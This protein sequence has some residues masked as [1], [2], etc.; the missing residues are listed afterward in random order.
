MG[1]SNYIPKSDT[2]E[3]YF[4]EM[5]RIEEHRT[6]NAEKNIRY[7]YKNMMKEIQS[8]MSDAYDKF[9][10]DE[11]LNMGM[12]QQNMEYSRF[13]KEVEK[14]INDLAPKAY[15]EIRK[16]SEEMYKVAFDGVVKAV[17]KSK[18]AK[19][20]H[21]NLKGIKVKP[22]VLKRNVE[23][24][25]KGLTLS[26]VLESNR[27]QIIYDIRQE[28]NSGLIVGDRFETMAKR[29]ANKTNM[30]YRKAI[31]IVRT[32]A[33]RAT[34]SGS[35]DASNEIYD[36]MKNS[37]HDIVMVK[38]WH[39]KK[40]SHVRHT[41]KAS[42]QEMD[43]QIVLQD[44]EF[45]LYSG[46][47]KN[48]KTTPSPCQSGIACQD[49]N[50][51]CRA[52]RDIMTI[53]EFEKLTGRKYEKP[54]HESKFDKEINNAQMNIDS[55]EEQMK[56]LDE[57]EY[58]NIWK[59]PVTAKDYI[60]KKSKIKAK[61]DYFN[62]KYAETYDDKY[63]DL[64]D[65]V[66][67]FEKAGKQYEKLQKQLQEAKEKYIDILKNQEK[68]LKAELDKLKK[69]ADY[70]SLYDMD[71][72]DF[73]KAKDYFDDINVKE[74]YD[75]KWKYLNDK[76]AN[77]ETLNDKAQKQYD[78]LKKFFDALDDINSVDQKSLNK[79][80]AALDDF[81]KKYSLL[82]DDKWSAER[83]AAA[84]IF[85]DRNNADKY[86]RKILDEQWKDFDEWQQ[87]SVWE[88]TQNSNPM[89]KSLS[90]YVDSWSRSSF[91]G[92][93]KA[94]WN[95]ENNWRT[96]STKTFEKKFATNGHKTYE[97]V[98]SKLTQTI[99]KCDFKDDVWLVRGSDSSGLA[100]LLEGELFSFDEAKKLID[101]N[102]DDFK[103]AVEG[104][105][106]TNH[107]FTST[108]I[109]SGTGFSGNIKYKIYAPKGTKGIYAE[110]QSYFGN[111]INGE[112]LYKV[113][114]SYSSVGSEA[115]IIIQRGTSYRITKV[116]E[117][118]YGNIEIEME[119]VEQPN[120]FN[121]GYE[122]TFNNG[123]TSEVH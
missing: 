113:G 101:G 93:G 71:L 30:S 77:G 42:H 104:Q 41:S 109:A 90:G 91:K 89:N 29:I 55:L 112:H 34:E 105:I 4:A 56:K 36:K 64:L 43:G 111:T 37:D 40:D 27:K 33:H 26:K 14:T 35:N 21:E 85:S 52:S 15:D 38:I 108:G 7:I 1:Q 97:K 68:L 120:Y 74:Y 23:N 24:P 12:I 22:E 86:Y 3:K 32:E 102:I 2:L 65:R 51:R 46:S 78:Y 5:K 11:I 100:G 69:K 94:P 61:K 17:D 88:Y 118:S 67:K 121:S 13:I 79:A 123:A 58:E 39:S 20:L 59:E 80:Q 83:K 75:D 6:A 60:D 92:L 82:D 53:A 106:F 8:Y 44:E 31:R 73:E 110:P 62:D 19:A 122:H 57:E 10:K 48:G 25:V 81:R 98:I 54:V 70:S 76:I 72:S 95:Y 18:N 115:E 63:L 103:Q 117:T 84:K 96:F 119:V 9:S 99:D 49:I 50:C 16:I 107:A 114:K 66:D 116:T 45:E 47:H 87:Y 28:I